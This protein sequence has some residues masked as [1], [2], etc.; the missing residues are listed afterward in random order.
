MNFTD[1]KKTLLEDDN[2]DYRE[3]EHD[4]QEGLFVTNHRFRTQTHFTRTAIDDHECSF[5]L[6]QT[7]QGK[8]VDF[9]TRITGYFSRGK[10]WNNGKLG[11]LKDR[12]RSRITA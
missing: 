12:Y 1:F 10:S 2:F 3:G 5:L 4:G 6:S 8:D 9:I 11:E 7:I